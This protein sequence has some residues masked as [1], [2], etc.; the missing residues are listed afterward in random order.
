LDLLR[1]ISI[2]KGANKAKYAKNSSKIYL[3]IY[4]EIAV[5]NSGKDVIF[6][7][8][9]TRDTIITKGFFNLELSEVEILSLICDFTTRKIFGLTRSVETHNVYMHYGEEDKS[10]YFKDN[11]N[12]L[13]IKFNLCSSINSAQKLKN[14]QICENYQN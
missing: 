3:E 1:T 8:L 13:S 6:C 4:N 14:G 10:I 5:W 12:N 2:Q 9:E 11:L 7:N